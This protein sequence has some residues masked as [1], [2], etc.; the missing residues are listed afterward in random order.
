MITALDLCWRRQSI[1]SAR[2]GPVCVAQ[3][4]SMAGMITCEGPFSTHGRHPSWAGSYRRISWRMSGLFGR[5]KSLVRRRIS[6]TVR[7]C[8]RVASVGADGVRAKKPNRL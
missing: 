7:R 8:G 5:A 4:F 1:P 3:A 2:A 6:G